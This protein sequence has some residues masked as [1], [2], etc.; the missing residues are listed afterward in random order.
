MRRIIFLVLMLNVFFLSGESLSELPIDKWPRDRRIDKQVKRLAKKIEF[1][2]KLVKGDYGAFGWDIVGV[3]LLY[4]LGDL[5]EKYPEKVIPSLYDIAMDRGRDRLLR[6]FMW[7][8]LIINAKEKACIRAAGEFIN[9]KTEDEYL[10]ANVAELLGKAK[11]T[12]AT[13]YLIQVM[14]DKS[15]PERVR[16]CAARAF[17]PIRDRRAIPC[18]LELVQSEENDDIRAIAAGALGSNAYAFKDTNITR[19]II[20]ELEEEDN[21]K[22]RMMEIECLGCLGRVGDRRATRLLLE[23][24]RKK[25]D[26]FHVI[27][28]LGNIGTPEC[29]EVLLQLLKDE[30]ESIRF[31]A[32]KAIIKTGDKEAIS[33]VER[34]LERFSSGHR[35]VIGKALKE[36][37]K[38]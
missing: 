27:K 9:N 26:L 14:E 31:F 33:E 8:G 11:D 16:W 12:S 38:E 2:C 10:R 29:K 17:I 36:A 32:A 19:F 4:K 1:H 6:N 24:A 37:K 35:E 7:E 3:K 30:D 25:K 28:E 13:P 18:L 15:N 5:L 34:S 20:R 23:L 21:W 22:V